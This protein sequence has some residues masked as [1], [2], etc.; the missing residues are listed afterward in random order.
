MAARVVRHSFLPGVLLLGIS[1]AFLGLLGPFGVAAFTVPQSQIPRNTN[2][3]LL[4]Q[5]HGTVTTAPSRKQP[6]PLSR[7]LLQYPKYQKQHPLLLLFLSTTQT[8]PTY[9]DD[10]DNVGRGVGVGWGARIRSMRQQHV[11]RT[12]G[13]IMIMM[14]RS[15]VR[16]WTITILAAAL[17]WFAAV[18]YSPAHASTTSSPPQQPPTPQHRLWSTSL[19]EMVDRYVK[20]HMFDD[21]VYDPVESAYRETYD[22]ITYGS[23]PT[24]L[25][26]ITASVLG[27]SA[28]TAVDGSS[29]TSNDNK[30]IAVFLRASQV[31]TKTFGLSETLAQVVLAVTA[32]AGSFFSFVAVFGGISF[33]LKQ[34]LKRELKKRYGEDYRYVVRVVDLHCQC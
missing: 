26:D 10:D 32:F 31:L 11:R 28:M 21:D 3:C 12:R 24:K 25:K 33:V 8:T 6:I 4:F 13:A 23:Y 22:D 5:N 27:K 15:K 16:K 18:G 30:V 2:N 29:E 14:M 9:S 7:R 20:D 17:L 34:N 1:T 19:D